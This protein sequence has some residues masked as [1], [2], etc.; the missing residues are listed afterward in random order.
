MVG[1]LW[2]DD[3]W[4]KESCRFDLNRKGKTMRFEFEEYEEVASL[5]V[6]GV[7]GAGGNAINRMVAAGL[8]GVEFVAV[9]TDEQVLQLSQAHKKIQIGAKLTKG[10]GAGGDPEIGRRAIE[11][12]GD[13][14]GEVIED[15][16]MVF[17]T[18]GM[19]GGTGTGAAPIIAKAAREKGA[20]TV[21]IVTRP[22]SFEGRRREE[23]ALVGIEAMKENVD[24]LIVIQ[25]DRLLSLVPQDT[26]MVE[27]FSKADEIL[28]QATKGI[29]DLIMVPGLIN[30]D[31]A[32]VRS[33]MSG[34]GD[35]LMGIGIASGEQREV[36]AA[37][38]ALNSPLLDD[39]SISGAKGVLV[40]I[41]G[42]ERMT[43][44]EVSKATRIISEEAGVE[45]N[46]IFGAVINEDLEDKIS[47]TVIATGFNRQVRDIPLS[48]RRDSHE[49]DIIDITSVGEGDEF[50]QSEC[51]SGVK[52]RTVDSEAEQGYGLDVPTFIRERERM[53][54]H[55]ARER[56]LDVPTFLR[57]QLD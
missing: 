47:L 17:V 31:F 24:T 21:G 1:S 36:E 23:Q 3:R 52:T 39:V 42:D 22:F 37:H 25:N 53:S 57:K 38:M 45:A 5:R 56:N 13:L 18:A 55:Y 6:V 20:L 28:H 4:N 15:T 51:I 46:V 8:E 11:E 14:I 32:D 34:M 12:N 27:A 50:N 26:P 10:L 2:D 44:H 9:N 40:N 19:G 35:A 16:D 41:T 33:I 30:L 54:E 48:F 7:G 49:E 43:L 29:S